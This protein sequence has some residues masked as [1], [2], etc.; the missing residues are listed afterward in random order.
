MV[1]LAT[2]SFNLSVSLREAGDSDR[3]LEAGRESIQ[4]FHELVSSAP[5][6][7]HYAY[8][9]EALI[10]LSLIHSDRKCHGSALNRGLQAVKISRRMKDAKYLSRSWS[11]VSH[12]YD[13]FGQPE[14]ARMAE[15]EA[16]RVSQLLE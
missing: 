10:N 8:L 2:L 12:C 1:N 13:E 15:A 6:Q 14:I 4:I 11:R 16:T 9:I 7:R 5:I 3:A